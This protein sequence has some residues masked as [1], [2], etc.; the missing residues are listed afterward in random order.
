MSALSNKTVAFLNEEPASGRIDR[1]DTRRTPESRMS[2]LQKEAWEMAG[3]VKVF[4]EVDGRLLA[5]VRI[6]EE[7]KAMALD[8]DRP[9]EDSAEPS[10][11]GV[12]P[13]IGKG[14]EG[15]VLVLKGEGPGLRVMGGRHADKLEPDAVDAFYSEIVSEEEF[16]EMSETIEGC[17]SES[18][19]R[20]GRLKS[21]DGKSKL[22]L[23][24]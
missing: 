5:R 7:M 15:I 11:S 19:E 16:K 1:A 8:M 23:V 24:K 3:I 20:S 18:E 13:R 21:G 17:L 14:R 2:E 12:V 9:M 10:F 22:R 4:R 6:S